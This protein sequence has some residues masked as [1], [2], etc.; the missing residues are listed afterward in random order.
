MQME[1]REYVAHQK[2]TGSFFW[3]RY[4]GDNN[5]TVCDRSAFFD[6]CRW[7]DG[8]RGRMF[9]SPHKITL[10]LDSLEAKTE[11]D[12]EI[13]LKA[14]D[15]ILKV[16]PE[17]HPYAISVLSLGPTQKLLEND[18]GNGNILSGT[19]FDIKKHFL[20]RYKNRLKGYKII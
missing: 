11:Q 12:H 5:F 16:I 8:G 9:R 2:K 10:L 3:A 4:G 20:R 6:L 14:V 17:L 15:N 19:N 7:D 1:L 18:R 13:T